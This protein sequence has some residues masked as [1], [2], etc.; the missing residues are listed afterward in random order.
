MGFFNRRKKEQKICPN[1]RK[2]V[3]DGLAF[4]DSCGLR[5]TPPPACA[6]CHL[7]LAPE[8]NFCE[9]C[10]TPVGMRAEELSRLETEEKTA[11][12]EKKRSV[13]GR[14]GKNRGPKKD[15]FVHPSMLVEE[16]AAERKTLVDP[17]PESA[18]VNLET[19]ISEPVHADSSLPPEKKP[20]RLQIPRGFRKGYFAAGLVV[21]IIILAVFFVAPVFHVTPLSFFTGSSHPSEQSPPA[22]ETGSSPDMVPSAEATSPGPSLVPGPTQVPP[23]S[24][25]I[26][27]RAERDPVTNKVTVLFD[28]GKGQRGVREIQV[29]LTRSDGQVLTRAFRP[30]T[31]G[32]GV[33]LQG[34]KYTDRLEV[35]IPYNNGNEY[36][37]IDRIFEYKQRN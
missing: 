15:E 22:E 29:R 21:L 34:T 30:L 27:L 13:K 4:C 36:T 16:P 28:G 23:E 35:S 7:P 8:T 20:A 26:W 31:V 32:E 1:C 24:L 5:V 2:P 11:A 33:I 18:P 37:V 25:Q 17:E 6:K 9:A 3:A 19:V 14:K 10:G 12:A